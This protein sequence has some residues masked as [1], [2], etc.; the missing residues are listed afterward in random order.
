MGV[1]WTQYLRFKSRYISMIRML[2][3]GH[4]FVFHLIR[5]SY[6]LIGIKQ[7][8]LLANPDSP[9]LGVLRVVIAPAE[10]AEVANPRLLR[11]LLLWPRPRPDGRNIETYLGFIAS[12]GNVIGLSFFIALIRNRL[13]FR[14]KIGDKF[15]SGYS[16]VKTK[17]LKLAKNIIE[18]LKFDQKWSN[19]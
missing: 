5:K 6:D 16:I 10:A 15:G 11:R 2:W 12:L 4:S 14:S 19:L 17:L 7:S 1:D 3:G 18:K 9:N 8:L 13:G